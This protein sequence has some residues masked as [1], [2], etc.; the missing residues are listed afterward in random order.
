MSAVATSRPPP[1][2]LVNLALYPLEETDSERYRAVIDSAARAF[3]Q[4]GSI[5]LPEFLSSDGLARLAAEAEALTPKAVRSKRRANPYGV[6]AS[7]DLEPGHPYRILSPT[8]RYGVAYHAM[9]ESSL[10]DFYRWP[11]VR[12][13][14]ADVTRRSRLFL[15]EDPSNALVLQIYKSGGG[16]AWHFDRAGF[17]SILHLRDAEKGGVLEHVPG[18]RSPGNEC[19]E[20]V[21]GVLLGDRSRVV[22][23]RATAGSFS[24]FTGVN[25]LHRVTRVEGD[26]ARVSL[27]LS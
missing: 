21:A 12:Q 27:V 7:A 8:D 10:A 17:S 5:I 25:T 4:Q 6:E 14:V 26:C 18:L 11:P 23:Q 20:E 16:L 1:E 19:F 24:I 22:P 15:H 13:F 3:Q 2:E 9:G